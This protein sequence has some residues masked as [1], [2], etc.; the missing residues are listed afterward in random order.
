MSD[1]SNWLSIL[2]S[3]MSRTTEAMHGENT[4]EVNDANNMDFCFLLLLKMTLSDQRLAECW[5]TPTRKKPR[6]SE[7]L[8]RVKTHQYLK[9]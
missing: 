5:K 7:N 3:E 4:N 8:L 9:S 6:K 2:K 1:K